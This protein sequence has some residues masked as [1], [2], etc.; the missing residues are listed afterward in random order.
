[1]KIRKREVKTFIIEWVCPKDDCEGLMEH[2]AGMAVLTVDKP[3]YAHQCNK[4]G[5][6]E[7]A[8]DTYPKAKIEYIDEEEEPCES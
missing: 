5:H 4:C 2:H 1:M 3:K 7:Y 8:E 6:D